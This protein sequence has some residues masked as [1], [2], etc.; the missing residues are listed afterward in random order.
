ME[1]ANIPMGRGW[2]NKKAYGREG[3]ESGPLFRFGTEENKLISEALKEFESELPISS[4]Q[5]M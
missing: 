1:N 3:D 2:L 5:K 4:A